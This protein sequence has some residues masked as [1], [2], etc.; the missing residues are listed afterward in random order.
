MLDKLV[1][2]TQELRQK[3]KEFDDPLG[4]EVI[5]IKRDIA[6]TRYYCELVL[7]KRINPENV[8]ILISDI[9]QKFDLLTD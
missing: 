5:E 1:K 6:A 3:A 4:A 7:A 8:K 2:L 9:R